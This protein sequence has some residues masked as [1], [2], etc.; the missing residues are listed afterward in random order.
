MALD[1]LD[2]TLT[3]EGF[4]QVD[5]I[6]R[7]E[8]VLGTDVLFAERLDYQAGISELCELR[9]DVRAKDGEIDPRRL[10]AT[11]TNVSLEIGEGQGMAWNGLVQGVT[12]GPPLSRGGRAYTLMIRSQL[13]LLSQKSAWRAGAFQPF[14]RFARTGAGDTASPAAGGMWFR[15]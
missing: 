12:A 11:L 10:I 8:T 3:N 4:S 6:I 15:L 14:H 7:I 5:R 9:V 1:E 2:D 13:S